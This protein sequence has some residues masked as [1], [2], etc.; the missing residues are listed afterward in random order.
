[1]A[2]PPSP[3]P[4][5][6]AVEA[7]VNWWLSAHARRLLT[8]ALSGLALAVLTGRP[9]FAGL[10]AP[11]VLLLAGWQAHRPA[12][13]VARASPACSQVVEGETV[14]VR[15]ELA[16]HDGYHARARLWPDVEITAGPP[17]V[18]PA[19]DGSQASAARLTFRADRPGHRP[20]G[21]VQVILTDPARLAE[22]SFSLE[23]PAADC[24]PEPARLDSPILLS[25][26][27]SRL[28]DHPARS[29]GDGSELAGVREFVPGDRQRRINWPATTRRGT[30]HLTTFAAERAMNVVV[31][32]DVTAD[33]GEAGRSTFDVVQRGAAGIMARY[34][35]SGDRVGLIRL[36]A[37]LV[38]ISPGQGPR[39]QRRLLNLLI[40]DAAHIGTPA[41]LARLP[42]AALPPGALIV[43]ITPLLD[44]RLVEAVRE[45][46]ERG[47][48]VLVL[49]VLND[50]PEHGSST[51]S[52][53]TARLWRLEQQAI[54][55]SL[56]EI[57][58]PVTHWDGK[59]SLDEPLARY[60][61]RP[62]VVHR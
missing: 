42:R 14:P 45:L 12:R 19:A 3:L 36:G 6:P 44:S 57:G 16:G 62:I 18:I 55:F 53:L 25:R 23:L 2:E 48:A 38:W 51:L 15:V 24:V 39:H 50:M 59:S 35:A 54:R 60:T 43:A 20:V 26:L 40:A 52:K 34:L 10:A 4:G 30:L 27:P 22:G 21:T 56:T 29:A 7:E 13:L 33:V 11:A 1:L 28:G 37:N 61:R 17:A 5:T 58:V 46:R 8:L 9:E 47:F 32:A 41:T 31:I 49:D